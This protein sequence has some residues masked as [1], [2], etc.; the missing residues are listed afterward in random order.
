MTLLV[1]QYPWHSDKL[2]D[3]QIDRNMTCAEAH[4]TSIL[5][6]LRQKPIWK[7]KQK[8]LSTA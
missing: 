7:Q 2:L 5:H 8:H 3:R 1:V 6:Y 4:S